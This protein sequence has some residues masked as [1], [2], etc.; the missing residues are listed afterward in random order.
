M[1]FFLKNFTLNIKNSLLAINCFSTLLASL[2]LLTLLSA[3]SEKKEVSNFEPITSNNPPAYT[4]HSLTTA[5]QDQNYTYNIITTDTD[6][7]DTLTITASTLPKW[8]DFID[9]GNRTAILSG[10]PQL[11]DVGEHPVVLNLTD[12]Q[13][14]IEQHFVITVSPGTTPS[15]NITATASV[16]GSISPNNTTVAQ[17]GNVRFSVIADSNYSLGS[18]T[19]CNG[20]LSGNTYTT[21]SI[22]TDCTVTALFGNS[23]NITPNDFI[24]SS[25]CNAS[26][27]IGC[28]A[29][30][31]MTDITELTE[32]SLLS[33]NRPY[34]N[35]KCKW[36][37]GNSN[38]YPVFDGG[39]CSVLDAQG[40]RS[41]NSFEEAKLWSPCY[42]K[43]ENAARLTFWNDLGSSIQHLYAMN[44]DANIGLSHIWTRYDIKISPEFFFSPE[45]TTSSKL[46]RIEQ[47]KTAL[48]TDG[49]FADHRFLKISPDEITFGP[50]VYCAG[51]SYAGSESSFNIDPGRANHWIRITSHYDLN[52]GGITFWGYDLT[53]DELISEKYVDSHNGNK[54]NFVDSQVHLTSFLFNI[55]STSHDP[56]PAK[57][58]PQFWIKNV[59]LSGEPVNPIN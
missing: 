55:H 54:I 52:S 31:A 20:S 24:S 16:G 47:T 29:F 56:N 34:T 19:G 32:V 5:I 26:G 4:S 51:V 33:P 22:T 25:A 43:V 27:V 39:D 59:I 18:V 15:F 44:T 58:S 42:D 21:G 3:C 35:A 13:T 9:N 1:L 10:I 17:G 50:V 6:S 12:G 30:N 28:R 8:L 48:C 7:T 36:N 38:C 37:G 46:Y 23:L 2:L 49:R 45:G 11:L 53:A 57:P 14:N 40:V 41:Q